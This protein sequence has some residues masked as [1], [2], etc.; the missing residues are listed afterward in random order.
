MVPFTHVYLQK[1]IEKNKHSKEREMKM[2]LE[3]SPRPGR[4][5]ILL[6]FCDIF[7]IEIEF[8]ARQRIYPRLCIAFTFHFFLGVPAVIVIVALGVSRGKGYG[9]GSSKIRTCWLT[10]ENGLIWLFVAPAS[11]VLLVNKNIV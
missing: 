8:C 1:G 2:V 5:C 10:V 3:T 7:A 9:R 6:F 4:R 11:V